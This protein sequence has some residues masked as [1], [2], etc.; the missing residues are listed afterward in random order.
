MRRFVYAAIVIWAIV[1]VVRYASD[2]RTPSVRSAAS[3]PLGREASL[4]TSRDT[5]DAIITSA[6]GRVAADPGDGEAAVLLADALTRAARVTSDASLP[7]EAERVLRAT[8]AHR[9]DDYAAARMLGVVLLAQHRFEDALDAATR[10]QKMREADAWNYAVAGDALLELG[11]Y[12]DAFDSFDAAA[13][14]RPDAGVYARIA[15]ARELQGDLPGA[16]RMMRMAV[17]ATGA[18]DP[19]ALAWTHA[20]IANLLL[21]GGRVAEAERELARGA[22]VFA[23]HPYVENGRVKL[24]V[25]QRRFREALMLAERVP[26]TPESL[27]VRGD[28]YAR[29]NMDSLAEAAYQKAERL[30][31]E[32]WESEQPQ[33]AALAR[34]LAERNRSLAEAVTLAE[35]GAAGRRDI[36]TLDALAWAY[37]RAGRIEEADSAIAGAMRTGTAD[38]RIRCHASAIAAARAGTLPRHGPICDPLDLRPM[39][40]NVTTSPVLSTIPSAM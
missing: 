6:R 39:A 13:A 40:Q 28:L 9:R 10:A 26:E 30:E 18:H 17:E 1:L 34:F 5:L 29:L 24:L 2:G 31:R 14:R 15:Y 12:E 7:L 38:P 33:P 21:L 16:V 11:R 35:R 36:H 23:G 8:L 4:T 20:Q 3:L 32:G 22:F 37:F 19:E 25:A 27:A